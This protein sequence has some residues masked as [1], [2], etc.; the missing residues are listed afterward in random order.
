MSG[1]FGKKEQL[2]QVCIHFFLLSLLPDSFTV[3]DDG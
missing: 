1:D 2:H 3:G